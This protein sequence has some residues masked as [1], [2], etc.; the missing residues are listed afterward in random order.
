MAL[1]DRFLDRPRRAVQRAEEPAA[2]RGVPAGTAHLLVGLLLDE[3]GVAAAVMRRRKTDLAQLRLNASALVDGYDRAGEA[4]DDDTRAVLTG[5]RAEADLAGHDYVGTEH[6][7]LALLRQGDASAGV[8]AEHIDT[9]QFRAD[10]VEFLSG[11]QP[12]YD[13]RDQLV[14]AAT[15]RAAVAAVI[16]PVAR[17]S[18]RGGAGGQTHRDRGGGRRHRRHLRD[19]EKTLLRERAAATS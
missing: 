9:D 10:M 15:R 18:D 13:R 11:F 12:C 3:D 2:V 6:L 16:D 14:A 4:F 5:A 8:M 19:K 7:I 1:L 17:R